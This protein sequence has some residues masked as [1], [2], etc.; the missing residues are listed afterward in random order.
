[1]IERRKNRREE[2]FIR[3]TAARGVWE[4]KRTD[5]KEEEVAQ[6]QASVYNSFKEFHVHLF[7]IQSE[8]SSFITMENL[9][10]KIQ[11]IVDN[12]IEYNFALSTTGKIITY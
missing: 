3:G 9:E 11:E 1:M 2:K 4:E 10:E 7:I 12:E 6:V 5:R 8:C